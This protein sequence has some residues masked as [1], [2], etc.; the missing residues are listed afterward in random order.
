MMKA[1]SI[2]NAGHYMWGNICDGWHLLQRDDMS[3]IQERVPAGESET[4]H[5]H[6]TSRQFFYILE[7]IGTMQIGNETILLRQGEGLEVP[8]QVPHRFRNES[9]S[10]VSFLVVSVPKSHGDRV[11]VDVEVH[12]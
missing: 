3:I 11:L 7:G 4:K 1:I 2:A 8:P 10:D 12:S 6:K 5:F 9:S